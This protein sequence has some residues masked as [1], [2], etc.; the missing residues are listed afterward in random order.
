MAGRPVAC[1]SISLIMKRKLVISFSKFHNKCIAS[2]IILI[3]T[4]KKKPKHKN[5]IFSPLLLH[6]ITEMLTFLLPNEILFIF[7]KNDF[8]FR[9]FISFFPTDRFRF[10]FNGIDRKPNGRSVF[11]ILVQFLKRNTIVVVAGRNY[12]A[13]AHHE[14]PLGHSGIIVD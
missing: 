14:N 3:V 7:F 2:S 6:R 4:R 11:P 9:S 12:A 13:A 1:L 10:N 8:F 5:P